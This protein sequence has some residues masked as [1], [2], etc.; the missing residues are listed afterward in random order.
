M[1]CAKGFLKDQMLSKKVVATCV[2]YEDCSFSFTEVA[3]WHPPQGAIRDG[4]L[5][6]MDSDLLVINFL[7]MWTTECWYLPI[8][9][10]M[11][12]WVLN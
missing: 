11:T 5:I 2:K 4:H 12:G 10:G 8:A 6:F 9:C 1:L 7:S 3:E